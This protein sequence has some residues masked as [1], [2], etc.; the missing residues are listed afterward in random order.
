[1]LVVI[2]VGFVIY[3]MLVK[4]P[5]PNSEQNPSEPVKTTAEPVEWEKETSAVRKA[6]GP[7]FLDVIIEEFYPLGILQAAD[8]TGDGAEEAL[9]DLGSG[10]AHTSFLALMRME[11]DKP[12]PARFKLQDG[13][14][15][16]LLLFS[17]ASALNGESA[18]LLPGKNAVYS[19]YWEGDSSGGV[20]VCTV[21]A[22][23]WN[24]R[25]ETFDFDSKLSAEI[26]TE[27]CQKVEEARP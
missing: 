19:G 22:Y 14:I 7:E 24:P 5:S 20:V 16:P 26:K 15:S 6:L 18:E 8:I 27:F 2:L 1:M 25:A 13:K 4:K 11:N 9:V 12:A 10:G 3:L 21:E 17:G 23:K